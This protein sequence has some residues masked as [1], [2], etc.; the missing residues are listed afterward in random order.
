[1]NV[2]RTTLP[3][4]GYAAQMSLHCQTEREMRVSTS[5]LPILPLSP[6][7]PCMLIGP[8]Q[9]SGPTHEEA[10]RFL[11]QVMATKAHVKV[12]FANA[13]F[14]NEAARDAA[15]AAVLPQFLILPDGIG[16]DIGAKLLYGTKFPANLNGTD[17]IPALLRASATPLRVGL[18]GARP[19]VA[20]K[21]AEKL[22]S[23]APQHSV[24]ALSHGFLDPQSESALLAHLAAEPV[25]VLLVA[26]GNPAQE[27]W[28]ARCINGAHAH[29]AFGVG[30]LFDFLAGEAIRAPEWVRTAR[31]EWVWRL[32]LEPD[33]LWRR[34]VLG[35]PAFLLRVFKQKLGR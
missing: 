13:H 23:L 5:D 29:I 14:V 9:I 11:G 28:I 22:R 17:F 8:V 1:M 15:F 27:K 16:V 32:A 2:V 33:R 24:E 35:N 4:S 20:Q 10:L 34:Y 31:L 18:V 3:V 7:A 26:M 6:P 25:D 12:G 19:G 30:A 21:A